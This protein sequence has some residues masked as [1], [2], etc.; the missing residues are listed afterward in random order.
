VYKEALS[1]FLNEAQQ[2]KVF[3]ANAVNFYKL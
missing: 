1:S 3:F 2:K